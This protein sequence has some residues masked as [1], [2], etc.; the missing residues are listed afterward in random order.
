MPRILALLCA[1]ALAVSVTAAPAESA[2][3]LT[4]T[5]AQVA[6]ALSCHGNLRTSKAR[7]VLFLHGT[8]ANSQVNWSWNWNRALRQRS[9]AYCNLDTPQN[10]N[11]DIQIAAEYV[12]HA[13]RMMSRRAQRPISIVGHSQGGMVARWSLKYWPDTRRKVDDYVGL[14]SSNHGTRS[15]RYQCPSLL[16]CSPSAWQQD[17]RSRFLAALN[18]G[19][20]TWPEVDY[21]VIITEFDETVLPTRSSFL[22]PN[23]NVTNVSVQ[24]LCPLEPVEHLA[25]AYSNAAWL[26]GLDALTHRG[27]ARLSRVSNS[28]CGA[29]F[30]PGVD[31]AAFPQNAV[32]A[33][34]TTVESSQSAPKIAAEP[35]LRPYAR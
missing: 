28:T 14:A 7:P 4:V 22:T 15:P 1:A 10:A 16:G 19:P 27:P 12:V 31:P 21:T 35:P 2:P 9:W 24:Q 3:R 26:I 11:G 29:P 33:L 17:Y 30:M 20:E 34:L 13:I 23:P 8:T 32:Q 18:D 5:Q 6:E 25:M